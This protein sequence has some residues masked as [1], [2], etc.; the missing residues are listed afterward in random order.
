[1]EKKKKKEHGRH[2]PSRRPAA[3]VG[4]EMSVR[5]FVARSNIVVV[6]PADFYAR[7]SLRTMFRHTTRVRSGRVGLLRLFFLSLFL[8]FFPPLLSVR[9]E[10]KRPSGDDSTDRPNASVRLRNRGIS[11]RPAPIALVDK[12]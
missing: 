10:I 5:S 12:R 3:V 2:W 1:M 6:A 4:D 7:T 9:I 8:F 11:S